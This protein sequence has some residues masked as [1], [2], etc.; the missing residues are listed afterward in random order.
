M[1]AQPHPHWLQEGPALVVGLGKTGLSCVRYLRKRGVS[2]MVTDSRHEPPGLA[3]LQREWPEVEVFTGAFHAG[4]FARAR[5][6]V[7]SPGVPRSESAVIEALQRQVAVVND[8]EL[9]AL[10][11]R[12]PV[13]A[14]T[15]S[16][17]KSTVTTLV[18]LMAERCGLAVRVGGNLGTPALDLLG[19]DEPD[20][21]ALE[22]SSFQ[23][24]S[25]QSLHAQ[26]ATVLN[27]SPDHL[28][29]YPDL[30]AYAQTKAHVFNG[31]SVMVLNRDDP[32]VA[33]FA[34]A[35]RETLWFGTGTP[36]EENEFG[37]LQQEGG[38]WLAR[39]QHALVATDEMRIAGRHN[40]ANALAALALG[41]AMQWPEA[42]MCDALKIF[43]GLAHRTQWVAERN[44]VVWYNDSKGTN[45][46]AALAAIEGMPGRVVWIG[47]GDGKGADFTPLRDA[48]SRKARAV[49]LIG[50]DAPKIHET[51]VGTEVPVE[52]ARSLEQAVTMAAALA[53]SGDAVLLSP[54]C[55]SYDMF[56]DF[57]H[58][59]RVFC[60]AV[61]R[62]T[63]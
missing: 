42:G 4:A 54:A 20:C 58:R 40:H 52:R 48:L 39:G 47:G 33:G 5:W 3:T 11:A 45:V 57:E 21:Y 34:R 50:R 63:A 38:W 16:N 61:R 2:V 27:V 29:R 32:M 28:D 1:A 10:Q 26:A 53:Q 31:S 12:A 7:L 37:L 62:V 46:G 43:T 55:A 18:G 8:I 51:L 19:E 56:S 25:V 23:L 17:G 13:V 49:V 59:G 24:E 41:T 60:E 6:I 14:I 15:G 36:R 9:F 30:D 44:G 35:G 22:L